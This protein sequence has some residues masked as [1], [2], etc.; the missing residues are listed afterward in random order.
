M[1]KNNWSEEEA[2]LHLYG[3]AYTIYTTQDTDLQKTVQ[4][5]YLNKEWIQTRN[6]TKKDENEKDVKEK[7]NPPNIHKSIISILSIIFW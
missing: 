2:K 1:A 3:G 6:V 5:A 4:E 7:E